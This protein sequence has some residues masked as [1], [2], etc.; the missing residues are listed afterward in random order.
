MNKR[1][2]FTTG[3]PWGTLFLLSAFVSP[4]QAQHDAHGAHQESTAA[5]GHVSFPNSGKPSAQKALRT[6]L[7]LLHSF[8]Y[9]R[10]ADSFREARR[11]DS[12][13]ALAYWMEA[14]TNSKL[15]WGLEDKAAALKV[16]ALLAPTSQARLALARTAGERGFG[17]AVEALYGEGDTQTRARRFADASQK[18]ARA[19]PTDMEAR[20]F[21]AL[22][23]I[24]EA[25][26]SSGAAS[27]SLNG[28]AVRHAQYV[29]DR[30]P[31][32]PGA[33]HYI[34]HASDNPAGAERGL[35]AAREYSRIAP[36]AEHALHMP[37]H[38][39]LPLG[40]WEDIVDSDERAWKSS[41]AYAAS[42][43]SPTWDNNWHSM[44]WLQYAYLQLGRWKDARALIDT[45]RALT[46]GAI[47]KVTPAENPDAMF[48]VEQLAFR[49][50]SETGDWKV[51]PLDSVS[52][53]LADSSISDR[54]RG[55]ATI[56][57]YQRGT[58]AALRG[59]TAAAQAA[60]RALRT[61]R[62]SAAQMITATLLDRSGHRSEMIAVLQKLRPQV[63]VNRYVTMTPSGIMNLN[64]TL[65]AALVSAG[66]AGEAIEL[67]R[68]A[69]G[70]RP[71]RAASML[72]LARAQA[73]AGDSAGAAATYAELRTMWKKADQQVVRIL[74]KK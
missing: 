54:A 17:E 8:E 40:L 74:D 13:L 14:F 43:K 29:F 35:K 45:A 25:Y 4:L 50:G 70:D 57:L 33:A 6:G 16:L 72:G 62:P 36:D 44:N 46:S 58:V 63:R 69:L 11:A 41:R 64:E 31:T 71:R 65:G 39:F 22:G 52:I 51:F 9:E 42:R 67:Y 23:L 18:W 7:A 47:G 48:A 28:E 26:F 38:I 32:H 21:A 68:E 55:M 3:H 34:I 15:V 12:E 59:D 37:S 5:F 49:Y 2:S 56:S 1:C 53:S 73:S 19:K 20:A 30:N 66:R 60:A 24:W 10:A 61:I 27:D